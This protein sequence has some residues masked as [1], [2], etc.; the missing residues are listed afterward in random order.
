MSILFFCKLSPIG[1]R[2]QNFKLSLQLVTRVERLISDKL[3]DAEK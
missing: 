1:Y 2:M 3:N